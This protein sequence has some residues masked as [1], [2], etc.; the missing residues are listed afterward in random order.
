[1]Q[2]ADIRTVVAAVLES[3]GIHDDDRKELRKDF[4]HLRKWRRSVEQV[5]KAGRMAVVTVL[6]AGLCGALWLGF[7]ALVGK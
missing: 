2:E 6:V 5:E 4:V 1:M 7:K 3:F